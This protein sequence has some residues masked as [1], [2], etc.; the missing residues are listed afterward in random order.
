MDNR[1]KFE[2]EYFE[3]MQRDGFGQSMDVTDFKHMRLGDVYADSVL[4]RRTHLNLCWR[5]FK[6]RHGIVT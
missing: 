5:E 1:D 6:E 4:G 2:Q 3:Q